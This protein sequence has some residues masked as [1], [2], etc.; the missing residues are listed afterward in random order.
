MDLY[1]MAVQ[2][3]MDGDP[4]N[5]CLVVGT[6]RSPCHIRVCSKVMMPHATRQRQASAPFT[7]RKNLRARIYN[8]SLHQNY[9]TLE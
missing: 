4:S 7:S 8:R 3:D 6:S 1:N 2:R 5:S 9:M